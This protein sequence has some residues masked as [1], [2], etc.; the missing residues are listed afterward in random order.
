MCDLRCVTCDSLSAIREK[1]ISVA[2]ETV[3]DAVMSMDM[4]FLDADTL[5]KL[6]KL[7]PQPAELVALKSY[8]GE[9][10]DLEEVSSIFFPLAYSF[11][12][13]FSFCLFFPFCLFSFRC[14]SP[15]FYLLFLFFSPFFVFFLFFFWRHVND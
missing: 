8:K 2:P 15:S 1:K 10:E 6:R 13:L 4:Q 5:E 9:L 7:E 14:F 12:F 3:R 11:S